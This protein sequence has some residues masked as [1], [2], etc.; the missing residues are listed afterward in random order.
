MSFV[1]SDGGEFGES[2]VIDGPTCIDGCESDHAAFT[3]V[4]LPA[5]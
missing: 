5:M 3:S 1:L 2:F 4:D